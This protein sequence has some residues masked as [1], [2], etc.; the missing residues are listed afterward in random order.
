MQ[1][2]FEKWHSPPY[3]RHDKFRTSN[4]PNTG[5]RDFMNLNRQLR[6]SFDVCKF[7][8]I[9]LTKA[10]HDLRDIERLLTSHYV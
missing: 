9:L 8:H 3:L 1:R 6:A 4:V 2:I 7:L 10:T 5:N